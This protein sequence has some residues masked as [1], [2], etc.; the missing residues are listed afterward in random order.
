MGVE[1]GASSTAVAAQLQLHQGSLLVLAARTLWLRP[2][3]PFATVGLRELSPAI[4][5]QFQRDLALPQVKIHAIRVLCVVRAPDT[6]QIPVRV[7]TDAQSRGVATRLKL[8][9]GAI[10]IRALGCFDVEMAAVRVREPGPAARCRWRWRRS[11][12]RRRR[13]RK[14]WG[15]RGRRWWHRCHRMTKAAWT[16][17]HGSVPRRSPRPRLHIAEVA[18]GVR[19]YLVGAHV[20]SRIYD[21]AV[22]LALQLGNEFGI[23]R[24]EIGLLTCI[25][26]KSELPAD[27]GKA[28]RNITGITDDIKKAWSVVAVQVR[29][30]GRS[31]WCVVM[32]GRGVDQ[33]LEL[34]LPHDGARCHWQELSGAGRVR[35]CQHAPD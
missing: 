16:G 21:V 25:A 9:N 26:S 34:R 35:A 29:V 18:T 1:A 30:D 23:L 32:R 33:Q 2:H 17:E 6:L 14:R 24:C 8:F 20:V 27:A 15:R 31:V 13:R 4:I 28:A 7:E 5:I 19:L 12:R 3:R 22:E 11:W 10:S